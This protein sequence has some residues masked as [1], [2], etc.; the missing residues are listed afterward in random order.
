VADEVYIM[1][2]DFHKPTG[3]PGPNFPF[4]AGKEDSYDF[5][6]MV[7]DFTAVIP[8]DK[9]NVIYGMYG[10]DWIVTI[11][12]K[13]IK[14]ATVLTDRE[15]QDMYENRCRVMNCVITRD[16]R[17][18]EELVEFID[19]HA[20]YHVIWHE[21]LVSAERKTNYLLSQGVDSVAYWAYG[22]Y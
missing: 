5:L 18:K 15:I 13:P 19:E 11:E 1:A 4:E 2:Y 21:D 3:S 16:P 10:Y 9:I 12:K 14:A 7:T 20:A 22:Y 17:T 6:H 8:K